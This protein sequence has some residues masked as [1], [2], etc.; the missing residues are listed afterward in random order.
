DDPKSAVKPAELAASLA[1]RDP[2]V[3]D[4]L[5]WVYF[6]VGQFRDADREFARSIQVSVTPDDFVPTYLHQAQ[7][8]HAIG[9]PAEAERFAKLAKS[10]LDKASQQIKDLYAEEIQTLLDELNAGK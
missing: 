5:G 1:P 9:D 4:T 3:L 7:S 8:K 2:A 10:N 6:R